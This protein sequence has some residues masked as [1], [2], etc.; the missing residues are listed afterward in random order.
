MATKEVAGEVGGDESRVEN[1]V[2]L[3]D[4]MWRGVNVM[5]AIER[6][7]CSLQYLWSEQD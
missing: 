6:K 5:A 4:A 2:E 3:E 7:T 1:A